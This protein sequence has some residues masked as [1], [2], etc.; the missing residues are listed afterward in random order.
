[1]ANLQIEKE[2]SQSGE[3]ERFGFRMTG[4]QPLLIH[5]EQLA[6]PLAPITMR[7]KTLTSKR[8]K[9]D[10]DFMEIA[11]TEFEGG[12]YIDKNGPYLPNTW[13]SATI[14]EGAKAM[15]KGEA[16]TRGIL[17]LDD[18]FYLEY[19]GMEK[20][21]TVQQLWDAGFYDQ[22]MVGNQKNRVLRTR[23]RFDNWALDVRL[24]YMPK[25]I[26]KEDIMRALK[27]AGAE[28]G[29]GDYRQRFGKFVVE[30]VAAA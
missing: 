20:V 25:V 30:E 12:L 18:L 23:P 14:R 9:L 22:R 26:E 16:T 24:F 2:L 27:R 29:F 5:N 3:L 11:R 6:N 10:E 28:L 21:K 13:I 4:V 1:M 15:R 8:K 19:P 7:M 17:F